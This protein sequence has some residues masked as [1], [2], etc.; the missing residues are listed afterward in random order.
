[1]G[2]RNDNGHPRKVLITRFS[3]LGDVCMTM[4]VVY[5]VCRNNPEV[6]FI[7][8]TKPPVTRLFIASP[9]NLTVIGADVKEEYH[10]PW[11]A[12]RLFKKLRREYRFDAIA[13]LHSVLR[14]QIIDVAAMLCGIK[15]ESI[16]KQRSQRQDLT[17]R[18]ADH[19]APLRPM[20][21]RYAD[22]FR[23]LGLNADITAQPPLLGEIK[24]PANA[25]LP[26]KLTGERRI[27]IAPFAA[28]KGKIYPEEKMFEA[29]RALAAMPDTTVLLFGGGKHEIE[30]LSKWA[31]QLPGAMSL[32]GLRLG[33]ECEL[34]LMS[35]CDV[36]VSMDS[37]NMHLAS[38]MGTPV[39]S[40]W[41]ATHPAAGFNG[42][43]QSP[44]NIVAAS[45]PCRPCSIF[46]NKVCIRG[47]YECMHAIDPADIVA[48][49]NSV[50][51]SR[52]ENTTP[53]D[54]K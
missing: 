26:P 4:P 25:P 48:K 34:W 16:D 17:S 15:V 9:P 30:V 20:I 8:L 22:V 45:L 42:W 18:G 32:A 28:H 1:M 13:D 27:A 46:G 19:A 3:A 11:G 35:Q 29:V 50:I 23:R 14:T 37:A 21:E 2:R 5:S 7:Y 47:N 38:L 49:V 54:K 33:F 6:E 52:K 43:L 51:S 10:G 39:V 24:Q 40:I 53:I 41:G 12:I 31:E 36:M 44:D